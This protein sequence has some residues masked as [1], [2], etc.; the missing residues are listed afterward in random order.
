MVA[1]RPN[2]FLLRLR[3]ITGSIALLPVL[4]SCLQAQE[5]RNEFWPE[6][7]VFVRSDAVTRFY[8]MAAPTVS[9]QESYGESQYGAHV[10]FGLMPIFRSDFGSTVDIDRYRFLRFRAGIRYGSNFEWSQSEYTEWRV[11]LEVTPRFLLP[12]DLLL[13]L[14][15][16]VELRWLNSEYSTRYRA[17]LAL[18]RETEI[19]SWLTLVPYGMF[20]VF[21][22]SRYATWN[23][24][25]ARLG[26]GIPVV[27]FAVMDVYYAYQHDIRSEPTYVRAIGLAV[28]LYF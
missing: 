15:N 13:A 4:M 11:V 2:M 28:S 23:R 12:Y 16:R 5:T 20:E 14:R 1:E 24:T 10:E 18:E 9:R 25:Q 7:N 27:S 6:L 19:T 21:Y 22:D 17:R 26:L 3:W 8:F